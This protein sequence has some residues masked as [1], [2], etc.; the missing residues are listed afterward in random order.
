M[1]IFFQLQS[2]LWKLISWQG[3]FSPLYLLFENAE[4][5]SHVVYFKDLS[6]FTI[7]QSEVSTWTN[8]KKYWSYAIFLTILDISGWFGVTY[9]LIKEWYGL[10]MI[11]SKLASLRTLANPNGRL[12]IHN[13]PCDWRAMKTTFNFYYPSLQIRISPEFTW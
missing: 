11:G 6:K 7:N 10:E 2:P 3:I 5:H 1:V 13:F 9:M 8:E 4:S 12:H